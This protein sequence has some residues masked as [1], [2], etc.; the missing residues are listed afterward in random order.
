MLYGIH[1][2]VILSTIQASHGRTTIVIAHRLS[3]VQNADVI[4][5]IK[6]GVVLEQGTHSE[7][8]AKGGLYA[9]LVER[10]VKKDAKHHE[11]DESEDDT[12]TEGT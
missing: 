2:H 6:D 7:L 1:V 9:S 11:G 5:A 12:E 3:T 10:Q 8:L 4:V